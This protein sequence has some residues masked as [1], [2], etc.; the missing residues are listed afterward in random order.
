MGQ[1]TS[2]SFSNNPSQK[3]WDEVFQKISWW[4]SDK[5]QQAK[6]MVV[7]AGALGNE[8]L[9]N[10]ALLNVGHILIVD[11]DTIEYSNL[12][13]SVLF[14]EIDC[15]RKKAEVA[16]ERVKEINPN[17]KVQHIHGDIFIDVGLGVFREMDVV[18][19]C[20][21]NRI[22][23]MY[24]NRHCYKMGKTWVDG[25]IENLNGQ[26]DV[27]K[28]GITCYECQLSTEEWGIIKY[29]L[30]CPDIA[31]RNAN[32]GRIPT[33]PI[34]SSVIGALQVQEAMKVI[35]NNEEELLAGFKLYYV[36]MKNSFDKLPS[37]STQ[38]EDCESHAEYEEII[39]AGD[40]S[41]ES[42]IERTLIWLKKYFSSSYVKIMLE[43]EV[44]LEVTT[45][46]T[47]KS[48]AVVMP[49]AHINDE[50]IRSFQVEPGEELTFTKTKRAIDE[51]FPNLSLT[52]KD[53][54]IPPLHILTVHTT[55]DIKF[56]ELTGDKSFLNFI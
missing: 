39:E 13:R 34:S 7:G 29:R 5:I 17:V 55:D 20:L 12:S 9:K 3:K 48:T 52:L 45:Q 18:I 56:V 54:G 15:D 40:L 42:T 38:K 14:R 27:Y 19:G 47:E 51:Q 2:L 23:R 4:D 46:K 16:A 37:I 53:V 35:Y 43:D 11:F 26:L 10:L 22:A 44:V 24:I 50:L 25:A 6:V 31:R 8:V 21:D 28:P 49:R 36:G 33:T 1:K 41:C 32:F 30:G